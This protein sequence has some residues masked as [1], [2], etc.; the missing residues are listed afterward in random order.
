MEFPGVG[1]K[2]AEC[3]ALFSCDCLELVPVD[4]HVW[5]IARKHY[6]IKDATLSAATYT[7]I[8]DTFIDV[9]GACA[10]WAHSVLFTAALHDRWLRFRDADGS[11]SA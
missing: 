10:G 4:T 8:T 7:K 6:G 3:V 9:F 1:R 5:Q 11:A 2:V